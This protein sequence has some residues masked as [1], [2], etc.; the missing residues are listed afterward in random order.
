MHKRNYSKIK[1]FSFIMAK[2]SQTNLQNNKEL[3]GPEVERKPEPFNCSLFPETTSVI[4]NIRLNM[5]SIGSSYVGK[6]RS[7]GRTNPHAN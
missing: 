7:D 6:P 2:F 3:L 5:S 4:T 1:G